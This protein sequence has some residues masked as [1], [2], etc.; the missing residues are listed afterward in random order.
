MGKRKRERQVRKIADA[1]RD[2]TR[3]AM[4]LEAWQIE[5]LAWVLWQSGVRYKKVPRKGL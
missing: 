5:A 4:T 2:D 3:V 1:L